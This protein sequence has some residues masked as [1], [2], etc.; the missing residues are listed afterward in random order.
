MQGCALRQEILFRGLD[1][2]RFSFIFLGILFIWGCNE[3]SVQNP[4]TPDAP[5]KGDPSIDAGAINT[6]HASL[7][8]GTN[9]TD[10]GLP[11]ENEAPDAG[12][13]FTPSPTRLDGGI[14][15]APV[16]LTLGSI[17]PPGQNSDGSLEIWITNRVEVA[18]IQLRLT[19]V[20]PKAGQTAGGIIGQLEGWNSQVASDGMYLSFYLTG[21][22]VPQTDGVLTI[23]PLVSVDAHEVCVTEGVVSDPAGNNIEHSTGCIAVP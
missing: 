21:N 22:P 23:I 15:D 3:A 2:L 5:K 6:T 8:A 4:A 18:G 20:T 10:S 7:D 13:T 9:V 14:Y 19:G 12:L 11:S 17:I 16:H 1:M